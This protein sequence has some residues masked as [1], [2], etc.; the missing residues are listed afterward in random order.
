MAAFTK[1]FFPLREENRLQV[2][3]WFHA[4]SDDT[5]LQIID[6]LSQREECVYDLTT[7]LEAGQSRLSFHLKIL[8]DAGIVTDRREGRWVYYALNPDVVEALQR[9]V[10]GLKHCC[11]RLQKDGNCCS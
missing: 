6:C 8:K 7:L 5:R 4:L 11:Q 3:Q 10:N 9:F 2:A 1:E